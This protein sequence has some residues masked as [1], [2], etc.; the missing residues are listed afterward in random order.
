MNNFVWY[1]L[2]M[3]GVTYLIRMLPLVLIKKK[4]TN[5]YVVSFLYYLP[6]AVLTVMTVPAVFYAT[7]NVWSALVGFI[8]ALIVAYFEKG[9]MTVAL[10]SCGGVL[11]TELILRY[12]V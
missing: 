2:T 3:A 9:L 5:K 6:Y 10:C 7:G 4:I 11:I 12:L 1:L 8:V